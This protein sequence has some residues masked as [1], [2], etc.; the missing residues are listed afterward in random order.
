M[1]I[2]NLAVEELVKMA[3]AA[4]PLWIRSFETGREILN[5][6]E[7]LKEFHVQNLS[8]FQHKRH[9]EASRDCGIVFADL[10]QLVRSFM[11]VVH[12]IY[13]TLSLSLSLSV[14]SLCNVDLLL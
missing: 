8:K 4:D 3:A 13:K 2:V 6:D 1:E 9:I 10:P 12:C 7:Y 14:L 5:Y 11:D